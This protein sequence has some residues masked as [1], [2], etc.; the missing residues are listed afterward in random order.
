MT[1]LEM[2]RLCAEAMGLRDITSHDERSVWFYDKGRDSVE[3]YNPL[4][5]DGQAMALEWWLIENCGALHFYNDHLLFYPYQA[6]LGK[7]A[8]KTHSIPYDNAPGKRRAICE[9]V[10]KMRKAKAAAPQ[11]S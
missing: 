8:I 5:D 10:A 1:D 11:P 4:H 7:F 6:P 2:T 9:C 3:R